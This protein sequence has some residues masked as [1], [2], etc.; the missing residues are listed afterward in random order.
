MNGVNYRLLRLQIS[1]QA[2]RVIL[3][4][5]KP[6]IKA[7]FKGKKEAML[8][9]FDNHA[10]TRELKAGSENPRTSSS[11]VNTKEGGN[12]FSLLGF[13]KGTDP[14]VVVRD[15]LDKDIKLDL[16]HTT[17]ENNARGILFKARVEIPNLATINEKVAEAAP[18]K[19]QPTRS[20]TEMLERGVTGFGHYLYKATR[21]FKSPIPSRSSSAI[22]IDGT[23]KGR[24][25]AMPPI[26]YVSD[27]IATF[28][29][30]L[31]SR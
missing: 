5:I 11:F 4:K 19:W 12:L 22:Q 14:T 31:L 24:S 27:V 1:Q 25:G 10:V 8:D 28:K 2:D 20:F 7:E 13:D 15:I 9:Y 29:K 6:L 21:V 3:P 17:K 30:L 26:R 23:I 16:A 18:V